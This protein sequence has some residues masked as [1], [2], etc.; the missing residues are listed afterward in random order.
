MN[1]LLRIFEIA[2]RRQVE[3]ENESTLAY[4]MGT[5][6]VPFAIVQLFI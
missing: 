6:S 5:Q 4:E 3:C 1:K 2:E